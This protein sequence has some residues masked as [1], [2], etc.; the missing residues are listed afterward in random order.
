MAWL[1]TIVSGQAALPPV[2]GPEYTPI[3]QQDELT[4][5][6]ISPVKVLWTSDT[7]GE[8][9]K[10]IGV[11]LEPG[12]SQSSMSRTTRFCSITNNGTDTSSILLDYGKEL[13]GGLQLVMGGSSEQRSNR[14]GQRAAK[15]QPVGGLIKLGGC[16]VMKSGSASP[17]SL[18]TLAISLAE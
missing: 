17:R 2:F 1:L 10:N 15:R 18:G 8:R 11:L 16:P 3:A 4:R 7:T 5:V 13:H 14:R 6:F 12:N 9:I